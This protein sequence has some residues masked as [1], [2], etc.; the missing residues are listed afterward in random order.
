[1]E[2]MEEMRRK[3]TECRKNEEIRREMEENEGK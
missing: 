1:M 3:S 2:E